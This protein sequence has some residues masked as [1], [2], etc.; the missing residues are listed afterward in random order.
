MKRGAGPDRPGGGALGQEGDGEQAEERQGVHGVGGEEVRGAQVADLARPAEERN[1]APV[2]GVPTKW[3]G[4]CASVPAVGSVSTKVSTRP[5]PMASRSAGGRP[6]AGLRQIAMPMTRV[7]L[8][9]N[10]AKT[11]AIA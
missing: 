3:P 8:V 11:P 9:K 6:D 7:A 4:I 10:T 5:R 2:V 1:S